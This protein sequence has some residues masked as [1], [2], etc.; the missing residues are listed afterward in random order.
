[1]NKRLKLLR[2]TL[3]LSQLDFS[4][5]AS[6]SQSTYGAIEIGQREIKNRHIKLICSAFNVNE[7][8][9]RSGE[10]NM[11]NPNINT[12]LG[13]ELA[14]IYCNGSELS[15]NLILGLSQLDTNELEVIKILVDGF[16]NKKKQ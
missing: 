7:N 13:S 12:Q 8:W 3:E 15:K 5:K 14:Q 11:F 16:I 2:T 9:L 1:M 6:L 10:G 4:K